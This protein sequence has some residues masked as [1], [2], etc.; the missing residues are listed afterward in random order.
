M[1]AYRA[2]NNLTGAWRLYVELES[3]DHFRRLWSFNALIEL[4][5]QHDRP[6]DAL[7]LLDR[8]EKLSIQPNEKTFSFL[9]DAMNRQQ[10]EEGLELLQHKRNRIPLNP[11]MHDEPESAV[12]ETESAETNTSESH[13]DSVE[14][15]LKDVPHNKST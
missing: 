4:L 8:M 15:W 2:S 11:S 13:T 7:Q 12:Q 1:F 3:G 5:C 10:D 9:S 14:W 6:R